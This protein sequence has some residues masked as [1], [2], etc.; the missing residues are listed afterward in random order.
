MVG[1]SNNVLRFIYNERSMKINLRIVFFR[2]KACGAGFALFVFVLALSSV[3]A[4]YAQNG[5]GVGL[6]VRS[7]TVGSP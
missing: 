6:A 1:R 7:V 4:L 5:S 3:A 2:L